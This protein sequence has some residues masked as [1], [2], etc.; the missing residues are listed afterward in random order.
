MA[1]TGSWFIAGSVYCGV[2]MA[3]RM[4][5]GAPAVPSAEVNKK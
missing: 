1:V 3:K 5:W 2:W 4:L